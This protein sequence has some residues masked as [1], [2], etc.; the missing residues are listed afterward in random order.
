VPAQDNFVIAD[1]YA[2]DGDVGSHNYFLF[3]FRIRPTDG[4]SVL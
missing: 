4:L 3:N 2:A 1:Y